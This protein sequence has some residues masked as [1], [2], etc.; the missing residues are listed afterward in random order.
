M[1]MRCASCSTGPLFI[2]V[3]DMETHMLFFLGTTWHCV[4]GR[5]FG[6]FVTHG[7]CG[8]HEYKM[9]EMCILI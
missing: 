7:M 8:G 9:G 5:N 6:S 2:L 4:V 3:V 1:V